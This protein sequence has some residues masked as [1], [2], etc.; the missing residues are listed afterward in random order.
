MSARDV[1]RPLELRVTM[2][3]LIAFAIVLSVFSLV[4]H[5]TFATAIERETSERLGAILDEGVT[6]T[7]AKHG[8]FHIDSDATQ[9]IAPATESIS[10]Y[11][12][13]GI[14][15]RRIGT[16]DATRVG[17]LKR[18]EPAP[19]LELRVPPA[20][21][22]IV[23]ALDPSHAKSLVR[24]VDFGLGIGLLLALL[25]AGI[26][27][28]ILANRSISRVAATMR[29]LRDFTADAAHE[30]RGPLTA[31]ASNAAAS[32]RDDGEL[33]P[34]HRRR[35]E[36]I[37]STARSMTRTIEDL[38]LLARAE[39]PL[40]RELFAI[41]LGEL[42]ANVVDARDALA[43]E[44]H[45]MLAFEPFQARIYGNPTEIER[46]IGNLLDNAIRY[47]HE[48]GRVALD[49]SA[50]RGGIA[51]RVRDTGVGIKPE[52]AERIFERFWREDRVRGRESG[53]G[54]GLAIARA[55]ARRHGGDVTVKS[56]PGKG[57]EFTLWLPLRPP[58][59]VPDRG[60]VVRAT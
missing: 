32:L 55:L 42:A 6:A 50:D 4:V 11:D 53:T 58:L 28:R 59:H 9:L 5:L 26:G 57:S 27:G 17:V 38:L 30:L 29:T 31:L 8:R 43:S 35:L 12:A 37:A 44:R 52:D 19:P 60:S 7:E 25:V 22:R 39:T 15:I 24:R 46:V 13:R 10:W 51:L 48:G 40:E 36:T 3:Y 34:P 14:L 20:P 2:S 18:D 49:S 41:E 21:S 16:L 23:A 1:L 54:L 47:T 45:I 33:T 56:T